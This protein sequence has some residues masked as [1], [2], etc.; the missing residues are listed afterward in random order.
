MIV[1]DRILTVDGDNLVVGA[2]FWALLAL[3][4]VRTWARTR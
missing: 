2:L 4:V 3:K 1:N